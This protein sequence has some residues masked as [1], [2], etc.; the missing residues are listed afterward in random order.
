[1]SERY[2]KVP[3][4]VAQMLAAASQ[5]EAVKL[6][7]PMAI[8]V[9]DAEGGAQ[10]FTRMDGTLPVSSELAVSKAYTAAILRMSSAEVGAL[11]QPGAALYGIES[12]HKGRIVLL[13][14]GLPLYLN[15]EVV[16]AVGVSGG[17]VEEDVTVATP[18]VEL[19][20]EMERWAETFR[21]VLPGTTVGAL[22]LERVKDD[23]WKVL[24]QVSPKI[25]C[26][27]IA[28][29]VGAVCLALS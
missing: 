14:G 7:K 20:Q 16:G 8:A 10:L 3:H 19:L 24:E 15:G 22:A 18:A 4:L 9:V 26:S 29:L 1:M 6:G 23:L 21:Q 17:S 11:A 5:A 13:G 12:T 28:T 25:S 2:T 27:G